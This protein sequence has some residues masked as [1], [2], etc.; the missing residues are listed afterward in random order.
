MLYTGRMATG[1]K[2]QTIYSS[3]QQLNQGIGHI[4]AGTTGLVTPEPNTL[5]MFGT[6]LVSMA[7]LFRLKFSGLSTILYSTAPGL[8]VFETW[9]R[10]EGQANKDRVL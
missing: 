6:G 1:T 9:E 10:G 2:T 8:A 7:G 4:R 3:T 5:S